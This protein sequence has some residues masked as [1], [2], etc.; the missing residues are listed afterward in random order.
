MTLEQIK[1]NHKLVM[2]LKLEPRNLSLANAYTD[3]AFMNFNYETMS[4]ADRNTAFS[5]LQEMVR[6]FHQIKDWHP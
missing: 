1:Q 5:L 6:K 3:Q 4:E 2:D